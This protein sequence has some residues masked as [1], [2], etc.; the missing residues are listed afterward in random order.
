MMERSVVLD[1]KKAITN[2]FLFYEDPA[3]K[4]RGDK[5]TLLP[6]W[7]FDY[8]KAKG[9]PVNALCWS[10]RYNDSFAVGL[11]LYGCIH[12]D[13][14]GMLLFYTR[15]MPLF[16]EFIFNT[17]SG[18][19]C[20]DI[21]KQLAHLVAVGLNNGCVAVYDLLEESKQPI[22]TSTAS[23]GKHKGSVMQVKWQGDDSDGNHRFISVAADGRVVS[24]TLRKHE[25]AFSDIIKVPVM[26]KV[27]DD[28]KD[29]IATVGTSLDIH[30]QNEGSFLLASQSGTI[31]KGSTLTP[32]SFQEAYDAHFFKTVRCVKWNPFHPNI[33]IS[34]G[35]DGWVKVWDERINSRSPLFTF[36]LT[37]EVTDVAWAPYS[38]SVFAAI[39]SDRK[40]HV[41]DLSVRTYEALCQQIVL[42]KNRR[43]MKIEFNPFHP[44][45]IV[46]DDQGHVISLKLSPN[47]RKKPLSVIYDSKQ[48]EPKE[49]E[50]AGNK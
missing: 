7:K 14:E 48:E 45:I 21:H 18:V 30:K 17:D 22:Y 25:L 8:E 47:L 2:D 41:F 31:Y 26:D 40:V 13:R 50:K 38:P 3:D 5:G 43:P 9:L 29:D 24:W 15:K 4:F 20:V 33:F 39:T 12:E 11:G 44:F 19:M 37:A 49:T 32:S 6:L 35:L 34:C 36:D 23:S 42:S 10:T 46:G 28:L 27:P 16:P 1:R